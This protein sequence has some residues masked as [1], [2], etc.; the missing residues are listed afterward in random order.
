MSCRSIVRALNDR[1]SYTLDP[2]SVG[3][4][5]DAAYLESIS[6]VKPFEPVLE[7]IEHFSGKLPMGIGTG[8]ISHIAEKTL[9]Q[10]GIEKYFDV[11]VCSDHVE[12]HKPF[13]D[14]FL[15]CAELISVS[16]A[17]CVVFEDGDLGIEAA[18]RAG[19]QW[20]DVMKYY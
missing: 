13:P 16:P 11:V 12:N 14:T 6:E 18:K 7:V 15:K 4:D 10:A 9:R 17:D 2:E 1:Y 5:K 3:R 8:T 19:M 20:V